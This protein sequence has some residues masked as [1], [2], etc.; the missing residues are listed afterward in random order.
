[1]EVCK[2]HYVQ[3]Y[4]NKT[5][6]ELSWKA[7]ERCKTLTKE[8]QKSVNKRAELLS[9][10]KL[11]AIRDIQTWYKELRNYHKVHANVDVTDKGLENIL[12]G[13][14]RERA[15]LGMMVSCIYFCVLRYKKIKLNLTQSM[16]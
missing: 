15:V 7:Y 16:D 5:A 12:E 9:K 8:E 14:I 1:M 13:F 3:F 4:S 10:K 6:T 2:K 11:P